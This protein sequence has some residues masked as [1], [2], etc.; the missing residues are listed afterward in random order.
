MTTYSKDF[1]IERLQDLGNLC[2]LDGENHFKT[3]A[4]Q[5]AADAL[6]EMS[7]DDFHSRHSFDDVEGVGKSLAS[8]IPE[9]KNTGTCEKLETLM[10]LY[11]EQLPLMEIK[12]IGAKTV[13]KLWEEYMVRT[14][15]DLK[16]MVEEG[17]IKAKAVTKAVKNMAEEVKLPLEEAMRIA[18]E[19]C[20]QI[21]QVAGEGEII[22]L[23]ACGSL[24]R[25]KDMVGDLD[26]IVE[27][28][29]P[30]RQKLIS[31]RIS[32]FLL[33]AVTADGAKKVSGRYEGMH[34][35]VRFASPAY[36]GAMT[37]YFTGPRQFNINMRKK[38]IKQQLQLN[39]YGLWSNGERIAGKTEK[40]IFEA[41][42]MNYLEPTERK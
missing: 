27:V 14:V 5:K 29:C 10:E 23:E 31:S 41:L 9:I 19:L 16:R 35:D 7:D 1:V 6:D 21:Y 30:E 2:S 39:E 28:D 3:R 11:G 38:A 8:K 25:Q 24:R 4:Y 32:A 17:V 37:L 26:I 12:G 34:V 42:H 40:E 33:D 36:Y 15:E 20:N 18:D 13:K 22:T